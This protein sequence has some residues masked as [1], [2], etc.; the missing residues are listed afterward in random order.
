MRELSWKEHFGVCGNEQNKIVR[1]A[2]P[3]ILIYDEHVIDLCY[4]ICALYE[5]SEDR[6]T[7]ERS[8]SNLVVQRRPQKT[9]HETRFALRHQLAKILENKDFSL[10]GA[11]GLEPG[12]R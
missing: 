6:E 12:T 7:R 11:P 8:H 3:N 4:R 5:W 9:S 1:F 10:V 2:R